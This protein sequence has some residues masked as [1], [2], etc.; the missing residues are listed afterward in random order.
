MLWRTQAREDKWRFETE[1]LLTIPCKNCVQLWALL[2]QMVVTFMVSFMSFSHRLPGIQLKNKLS[3]LMSYNEECGG[4][5][6]P[7]PVSQSSFPLS[8]PATRAFYSLHFPGS[9]VPWSRG[10]CCSFNPDMLFFAQQVSIPTP[11]EFQLSCSSFK[12]NFL[13]HPL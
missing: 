6:C 2:K 11:S 8:A 10:T 4:E 12:R 9:L 13:E 1:Q 3:G 7:L 5:I